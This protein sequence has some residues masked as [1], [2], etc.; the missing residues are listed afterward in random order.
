MFR[1][2]DYYILFHQ[3]WKLFVPLYSYTFY[4][5][6]HKNDEFLTMCI[7]HE[8]SIYT[9]NIM[10]SYFIFILMFSIMIVKN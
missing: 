6:I 2:L 9:F 3:F 1:V 10:F 8:V 7:T 4:L 5:I